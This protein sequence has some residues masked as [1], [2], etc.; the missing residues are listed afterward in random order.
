MKDLL[1][2]LLR[3]T[4]RPGPECVQRRWNEYRIGADSRDPALK[5]AADA[6]FATLLACFGGS[7]YRH[8]WGF[9]RTDAADDVFQD[10]LQKL[11]VQRLNPR[12]A[13]F[14][15]SVLP[16]LRTVAIH[17]CVDAHRRRVRRQERESRA[18]WTSNSTFG[19][20]ASVDLQELLAVALA[21]LPLDYQK[22][23]A[24]HYFEG[25]DRQD[26]AKA[27]GIHPDTL[28]AHL[29]AALKRLR[30]LIATP[31]GILIGGEFALTSALAT[32][33]APPTVDRM[34]GLASAA[35]TNAVKATRTLRNLVVLVTTG[36]MLSGATA[37]AGWLLMPDP[38]GDIASIT[39]ERPSDNR[40]PESLQ[41]R[42]VRIVRQE[43]LPTLLEIAK[44]MVPA[45]NPLKVV[46]VTAFGSEVECSFQTERGIIPTWNPVGL[47]VRYCTLMRVLELEADIRGNGSWKVVDP[48]RPVILDLAIP[49][50]PVPAVDLGRQFV[51]DARTAFERIPEDDRTAPE[52]TRRLFGN[53]PAMLIV[54][55]G[56]KGFT[57]HASRIYVVTEHR[58]IFSRASSGHW[59][60]D[61][62][63]PGWWLT[64]HSGRLYCL[65][66]HEIW[67]RPIDAP[68]ESWARWCAAPT[69]LKDERM[70][71]IAAS[72]ARL[73]AFIHPN[74]I[75]SRSLSEP[76]GDW[77]REGVSSPIW[78]DGVAAS[79]DQ[80]FAHDSRQVLRRIADKPGAAWVPVA[81]WPDNAHYLAVDGDRL[82]S[83]GAPGPILARSLT[84]G[85][86]TEWEVVGHMR[87]PATR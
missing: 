51:A 79:S 82:L 40:R 7:L 42:N 69:L 87:V 50:V 66:D 9:V 37:V 14:E 70:G 83:C 77:S 58:G 16:W 62:E 30:R 5:A 31:V 3:A 22:A 59:R 4:Q 25:L 81:R 35:W 45:E 12:L 6:A 56:L 28:S 29:D 47:K 41:E 21:K 49:G 75:C 46:D 15:G 68:S 10:V 23:V 48:E 80:L 1:E 76:I 18:A 11:H 64:A 24:L 2:K 74:V 72:N 60:F 33:P 71:F 39:P 57:A 8:I 54:P 17:Q 55:S 27:L 26:A 73:L 65:R 32:S 36:L 53:D 20:E 52:Q 78:P 13:S 34:C 38:A 44:R 43:V 84:A 85:I 19:G 86:E 61:G 67:M 63:C